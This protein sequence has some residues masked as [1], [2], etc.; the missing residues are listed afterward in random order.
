MTFEVGILCCAIGTLLGMFL[1]N[2][3]PRLHHPIFNSKEFERVTDDA[4]FISIE[5]RDG[6]F[7]TDQTKA[8]LEDIGATNIEL[9]EAGL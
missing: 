4:F 5:A 1:L 2:G 3:L 9:V 7:D 8:F 6:Q